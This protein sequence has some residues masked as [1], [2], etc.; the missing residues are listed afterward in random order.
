MPEPARSTLVGEKYE[1]LGRLGAGGMGEVWEARHHVTGRR[2]AVKLLR[3]GTKKREETSKRFL[4]EAQAIGRLEHAHVVEVLDAGIDPST[5]APYIVQT[6]LRGVSL[7]RYLR[8]QSRLTTLEAASIVAPVL[9]GLGAAHVAG[10]VHRDIKPSNIILCR[11]PD[12]PVDTV[13]PKIIDFGISKLEEGDASDETLSTLT[14]SGVALGTVGYMAPEQ[15]EGREDVDGRADLWAVGVMLFEMVAGRRPFDG[16]STAQMLLRIVSH[17][18]PSLAELG[19]GEISPGFADVVARA[20]ARRPGDRYLSALEMLEALEGAVGMPLRTSAIV[21]RGASAAALLPDEEL[22]EPAPAVPTAATVSRPGASRDQPHATKPAWIAWAAVAIA[23]SATVA[24]VVRSASS[25]PTS[26]SPS[27]EPPPDDAGARDDTAVAPVPAA[28]D[29][30]ADDAWRA[31]DA[32]ALDT[33]P[34]AS[35]APD[36]AHRP[37]EGPGRGSTARA[38]GEPDASA[39]RVGTHG[40]VI[41]S[42]D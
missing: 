37:H 28:P 13:T 42:A 16:G 35:A 2:V 18:A 3:A 11:Q 17:D 40:S 5:R 27:H 8:T 26:T 25:D 9:R 15:A 29:A 41:L 30:A 33:T 6:L 34:D 21:L 4:R 14:A 20:L 12:D 10:I 23:A 7:R 39:P 22:L 38:H 36:R 24:V 32:G 1:L 19:V 31:L